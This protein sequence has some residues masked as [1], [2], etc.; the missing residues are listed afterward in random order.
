MVLFAMYNT[1]VEKIVNI[2]LLE[3]NFPG[4]MVSSKIGCSLEEVLVLKVFHHF[5]FYN[6]LQFNF[7]SCGNIHTFVFAFTL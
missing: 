2:F 7:Y 1:S 4:K 3:G 5:M 6:F